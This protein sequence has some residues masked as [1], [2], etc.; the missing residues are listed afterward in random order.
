M[1][2]VQGF[3]Y[4]NDT[5]ASQMYLTCDYCG[6]TFDGLCDGKIRMSHAYC[7]LK[8]ADRAWPEFPLRSL[9]ERLLIAWTSCKRN[10]D[11]PCVQALEAEARKAVGL[12]L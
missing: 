5:M 6:N 3:E 10:L 1:G 12:D 11:D 4:M 8:C 2:L 9:V 7:S